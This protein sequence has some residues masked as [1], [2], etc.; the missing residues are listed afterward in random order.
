MLSSIGEWL[1][2]IAVLY[3][4]NDKGLPLT[5]TG[6]YFILRIL[7]PIFAEPIIRKVLIIYFNILT[8]AQIRLANI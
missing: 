5:S 2:F 6:I 1:T 7:P 4:L 3:F 8:F